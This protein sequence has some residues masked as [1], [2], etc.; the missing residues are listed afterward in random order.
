MVV[1]LGLLGVSQGDAAL[2]SIAFGMLFL[3]VG[4]LG[5][6]LWLI[7]G[8]KRPRDAELRDLAATSESV[9]RNSG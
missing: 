1:G 7:E 3:L 2:V 8:A 9:C 4:L 5:G 6:L